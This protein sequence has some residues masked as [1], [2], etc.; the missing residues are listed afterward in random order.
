MPLA[1]PLSLTSHLTLFSS[2]ALQADAGFLEGVVRGYKNGLLTQ[3]NY[4]NLTQC[5]T[6]EGPSLLPYFCRG[7]TFHL[8]NRSLVWSDFRLQL[9]STDYGGFLANE[10]LPISTA[11]IADKVC[12]R[13]LAAAGPSEGPLI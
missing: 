1:E 2:L 11:T 5:E 9:S 3:A 6:L 12:C 13:S 8:L 7:C 10:P 4:N